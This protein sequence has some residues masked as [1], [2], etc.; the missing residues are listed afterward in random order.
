MDCTKP[1]GAGVDLTAFD[2]SKFPDFGP[3]PTDVELMSEADL[4]KDMETLIKSKPQSWMEILQN[5][6]GQPYPVIYRAFGNLRHRLGRIDD[7][8]WYR[9]VFSDTPFAYEATPAAPSKSAPFHIPS[10]G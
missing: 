10:N 7:S 1:Y 2:Y 8:P 5:Y 9:Y 3:F 4:T 6:Y